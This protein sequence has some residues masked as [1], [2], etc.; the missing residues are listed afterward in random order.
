[1]AYVLLI[2]G[3]V[4]LVKGADF[5]VSGSSSI[6]R[7]FKIPS[8]IIGLTIVAFG[9]SA[10][11]AAVSITAAFKG[12]NDIALGNVVGSNLFN[13]L[14]V[15][16]IC[17]LI[18][19]IGV[20][21]SI[22]AKEFP[23]SILATVALLLMGL[24]GFFGGGDSNLLSRNEAWVLIL[25]FCIFVFMLVTSA[26]SARKSGEIV[27]LA[28][29]AQSQEVPKKKQPLW[30][31]ILLAVVGLAGIIG[32]GQLVVNSA[33]EIA[34][35][36]GI[37]ESLIGLTIVAIGTSLPELVTSIVAATKGESDIAIGNVVGSNIFNILFVLALSAAI[38]PIS[39]DLNALI[40]LGILIAVS[41]LTYVFA[42][43]KKGV[44]RIEGGILVSLY[45]GYMVYIILR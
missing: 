25:F 44:N 24:D 4:F 37:S 28:D 41:L 13:L 5:F 22:L 30:K 31:S 45:I 21:T 40:D 35:S 17:A 2:I 27:D 38:H 34:L 29:D 15:V 11:E 6:A 12:Q 36:F 18:K 10:P 43:A 39:F 1:M 33:R 9:T 20:K 26:L 8:F 19:P 32:G 14:A 3:F 23:F 7:F 42:I 16:G